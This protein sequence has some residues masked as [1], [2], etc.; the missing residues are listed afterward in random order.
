MTALIQ[1]QMKWTKEW[2][3]Q[4]LFHFWESKVFFFGWKGGELAKP[5]KYEWTCQGKL[6]LYYYNFVF[7]KIPSL[8]WVRLLGIDPRTTHVDIRYIDTIYATTRMQYWVCF[9]YT[10]SVVV[11]LISGFQNRCTQERVW[12]KRLVDLTSSSLKSTI[13][14]GAVM[15]IFLSN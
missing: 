15:T 14:C 13:F 10:K 7:C 1:W 5:L 12:G 3:P 11:H 4:L 8:C 2:Q 6:K 9:P